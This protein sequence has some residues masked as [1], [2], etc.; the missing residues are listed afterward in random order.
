MIKEAQKR[1][2]MIKSAYEEA[3]QFI[4]AHGEKHFKRN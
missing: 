4:E 3:I 2:Q 1:K